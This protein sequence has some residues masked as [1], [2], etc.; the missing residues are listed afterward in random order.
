MVAAGRWTRTQV[1][2]F[3][4]GHSIQWDTKHT[5]A[6]NDNKALPGV[7]SS[8]DN[9]HKGTQTSSRKG[10]PT[11]MDKSCSNCKEKAQ[12]SIVVMISSVGV[13]PRVQQS[14]PAVLFCEGCFRELSDRLCSDKL[15]EAVNNALT[16][17]NQRV[18]DNSSSQQSIFD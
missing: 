17:L 14:S 9:W 6:R 1:C 4:F 12:Y 18:R 3:Q 5:R 8:T 15:R 2:S 7:G 13:S 10:R 16:E 11:K